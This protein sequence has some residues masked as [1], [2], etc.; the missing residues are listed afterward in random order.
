MK[1]ILK[2]KKNKY[3]FFFLPRITW[4]LIT[5]SWDRYFLCNSMMA[6]PSKSRKGKNWVNWYTL[7]HCNTTP[8]SCT[9]EICDIQPV[10]L[11]VVIFL[12]ILLRHIYVLFLLV[13]AKSQCRFQ[14]MQLMASFT[15]TV[16]PFLSR[17]NDRRRTLVI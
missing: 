8:L 17:F 15:H 13:S 6:L 11:F 12:F 14:T 4:I 2:N 3:I 10:V 16:F 9:I 1:K 7:V 5:L